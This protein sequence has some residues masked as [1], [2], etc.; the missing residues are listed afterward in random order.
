MITDH[1]KYTPGEWHK[2]FCWHP[3][4]LADNPG[5]MVWL[6]RVWRKQFPF[7]SKEVAKKYQTNP[8]TL[9]WWIYAHDKDRILFGKF[10]EY[11]IV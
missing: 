11:D 9:Q 10:G 2:W 6:G 4:P 7:Q 1:P 3:A 5:K 8:P